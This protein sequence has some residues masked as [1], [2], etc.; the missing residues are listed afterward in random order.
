MVRAVTDFLMDAGLID[1]LNI[2]IAALFCVV[3][4]RRPTNMYK[5]NGPGNGAFAPRPGHD[6]SVDYTTSGIHHVMGNLVRRQSPRAGKR[7]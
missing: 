6:V 7:R 3:V 5:L 4:S 1:L 2:L